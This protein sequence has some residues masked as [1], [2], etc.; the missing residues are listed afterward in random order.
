MFATTPSSWHMW[1]QAPD[2]HA[3]QDNPAS[4]ALT[5]DGNCWRI[6]WPKGHLGIGFRILVIITHISI[7]HLPSQP[8][9]APH[10]VV[11]WGFLEQVNNLQHYPS[12]DQ[13]KDDQPPQEVIE[14][15]QKQNP[16][17]SFIKLAHVEHSPFHDSPIQTYPVGEMFFSWVLILV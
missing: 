12:V 7:E 4:I 2:Q 11:V 13:N 1:H 6:P 10:D 16:T 9:D 17:G 5:A 3:S 15:S 8:L 14:A